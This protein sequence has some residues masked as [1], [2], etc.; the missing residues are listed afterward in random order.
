MGRAESFETASPSE[1]EA[2]HLR[3]AGDAPSVRHALD[4][5]VTR[6]LAMDLGEAAAGVVEIALAEALNNVV[7]HAYAGEK[8]G[9]V[10]LIVERG[11]RALGFRILDDGWAMPGGTAP[12]GEAVD[13]DVALE[14]LPEGGFGWFLI[15][16]LTEGLSYRRL[17]GR[18]ELTFQIVLQP[19]AGM[20]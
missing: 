19:E 18:N 13:L 3:F 7:E 17:D 11:D 1:R 16:E 14:D 12:R 9:A 2:L 6:L 20:V 10:E 8:D 15:H 5:A 4:T